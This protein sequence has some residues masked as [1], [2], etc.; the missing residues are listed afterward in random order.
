MCGA[1]WGDLN[2]NVA[3]R[4]LGYLRAMEA[5]SSEVFGI[6]EAENLIW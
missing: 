1:G 3:C 5:V 2:S 4:Q 6:S